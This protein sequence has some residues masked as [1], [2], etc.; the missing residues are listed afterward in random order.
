MKTNLRH[1]SDEVN[2]IMR[3]GMLRVEWEAIGKP[4]VKCKI[5][6]YNGQVYVKTTTI[7][8]H[9]TTHIACDTAER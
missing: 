4:E 6:E 7:H 2:K 5:N 1:L 8:P 3:N 9:N